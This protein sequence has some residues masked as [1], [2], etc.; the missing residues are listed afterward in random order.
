MILVTWEF[1]AKEDNASNVF[2]TKPRKIFGTEPI[3]FNGIHIRRHGDAIISISQTDKIRI[4][5]RPRIQKEFASQK[6]LF[7]HTGV[8]K[9]PD[10]CSNTQRIAPGAENTTPYELKDFE[11]IY[12]HL[13]KTAGTRM[14]FVRLDHESV[15]I[16]VIT[17][18]SFGNEK[19]L[20]SQLGFLIL[21]CDE[22][23][24]ANIV[25][26]GSRRCKRVTRY[27][28]AAE[29]HSLVIVFDYEF[30]IRDMVED[31]LDKRVPLEAHVDSNTVF[32]V[33]AEDG[34][35][36]E[37]RLRINIFPLKESYVNV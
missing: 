12:V 31:M 25:H 36:T 5:R 19:V 24:N 8:N 14:S 16:V 4:I 2:V 32:D 11:K 33:V 35:T 6:A 22:Q 34:D 20:Q 29:I 30:V 9:G 1:S 13:H 27:V 21:L 15:K 18:A 23:G 10:V 7:Q 17:Y 26:N 28:M 37:K 3:A